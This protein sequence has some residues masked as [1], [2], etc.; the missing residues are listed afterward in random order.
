M[1]THITECSSPELLPFA[2]ARIKA[3]RATGLKYASQKFD[4]NG[5]RV[6]V[7]VVGDQD[8]INISGSGRLWVLLSLYIAPR[9]TGTG[10]EH[11]EVRTTLISKLYQLP[12][13]H[14]ASGAKL[15]Y[16]GSTD[17]VATFRWA[18]GTPSG[19]SNL[20]QSEATFV[21]TKTGALGAINGCAPYNGSFAIWSNTEGYNGFH[22]QEDNGF[23]E[24]STDYTTPRYTTIAVGGFST[25]YSSGRTFHEVISGGITTELTDIW[26]GDYVAVS[27]KYLES[28]ELGY[29]LLDVGLSETFYALSSTDPA[30]RYVRWTS[31]DGVQPDPNGTLRLTSLTARDDTLPAYTRREVGTTAQS[32]ETIFENG[33]WYDRRKNLLPGGA[34]GSNFVSATTTVRALSTAA[35]NATFEVDSY[36]ETGGLVSQGRIKIS[37][38]PGLTGDDDFRAFFGAAHTAWT[39]SESLVFSQIPIQTIDN[40]LN[41]TNHYTGWDIGDVGGFAASASADGKTYSLFVQFIPDQADFGNLT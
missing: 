16:S 33:R 17:R 9:V 10:G 26:T 7:R 24:Q 35:P 38:L 19:P 30:Y 11:A 27:P 4:V 6:D 3:L 20:Y 39:R 21:D 8:Y 40:L 15:R 37:A 1:A 13:D 36:T 14:A 18:Y 2:R 34:V 29:R 31:S 5:A 22:T 28:K 23:F 25:T 32:A 41:V 12:T